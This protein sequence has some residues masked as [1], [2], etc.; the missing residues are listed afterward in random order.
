MNSLIIAPRPNSGQIESA[1]LTRRGDIT[2]RR[3]TSV[4]AKPP[5]SASGDPV[6]KNNEIAAKTMPGA[7]DKAVQNAVS[8]SAAIEV[9]FRLE[10]PH[11]H[12]V[13]LVGEFSQW[14]T[15]P[16]A[17]TK[18]AGGVWH[19]TVALSPGPHR[20][21][22]LVDGDWQND[23]SREERV[24]NPYGSFDNVAEIP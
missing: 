7:A 3:K 9:V 24:A 18:G 10:A 4:A 13:L 2:P 17:M 20:Y 21:R 22:F 19:A 23:P 12:T 11:A 16:I 6:M 5:P 1:P 15:A 14:E 8:P